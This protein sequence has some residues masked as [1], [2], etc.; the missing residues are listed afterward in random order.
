MSCRVLS[1][2]CGNWYFPEV[3]ISE[4]SFTQTNIASLIFL[5][6]PCFS[7]CMMLKHSGLSGWPVELLFW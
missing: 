3:S 2:K 1:H 4:G 5:D 7:L 6:V